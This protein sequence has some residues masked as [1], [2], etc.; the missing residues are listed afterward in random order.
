MT[1]IKAYND[2]ELVFDG[3]LSEFIQEQNDSDGF[4]LELIEDRTSDFIDLGETLNGHWTIEV[5]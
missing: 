2:K 3:T 1:N 4:L 5:K